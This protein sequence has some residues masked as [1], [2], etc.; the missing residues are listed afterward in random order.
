MNKEEVDHFYSFYSNPV[1]DLF[2]ELQ[3][4]TRMNNLSLFHTDNRDSADLVRW[5]SQQI[6]FHGEDTKDKEE[7]V[8]E[9]DI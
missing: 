5:L 2:K 6:F 8:H 1:N 7:I 4:V 3:E 9:E